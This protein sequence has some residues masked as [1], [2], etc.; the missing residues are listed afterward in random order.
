MHFWDAMCFVLQYVVYLV[1][2]GVNKY[3][4]VSLSFAFIIGAAILIF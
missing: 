3:C 4:V 2:H 1:F